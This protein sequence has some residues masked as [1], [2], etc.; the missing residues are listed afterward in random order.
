MDKPEQK[1]IKCELCKG[2]REWAGDAPLPEPLTLGYPGLQENHCGFAGASPE[3]FI[4]RCPLCDARDQVKLE[5][6][7]RD[8]AEAD[9]L[10]WMRQAGDN[11][12]RFNDLREAV[13]AAGYDET[14]PYV[15]SVD[16]DSWWKLHKLA[17]A[18]HAPTPEA[19]K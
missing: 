4:F 18:T 8:A 19:S 3:R 7:K 13:L 9:S 5:R 15:I 6:F 11:G 1:A 12:Q 2:L 10:R 14:S 16:A 17:E